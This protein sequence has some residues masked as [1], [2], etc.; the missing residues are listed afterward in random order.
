MA[1]VSIP[2][3]CFFFAFCLARVVKSR[4]RLLSPFFSEERG[5][6]TI[7]VRGWHDFQTSG[8][9]EEIPRLQEDVWLQRDFFDV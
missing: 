2:L 7:P 5:S 1:F 9:E 4:W 3:F 8:G 6:E